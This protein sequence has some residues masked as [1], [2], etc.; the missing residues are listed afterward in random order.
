MEDADVYVMDHTDNVVIYCCMGTGDD[1]L[2]QLAYS[3][4]ADGNITLST[5]PPFV[6]QPVTSYVPEPVETMET[7]TV[8]NMAS[9]D[10]GDT[11]TRFADRDRADFLRVAML[12]NDKP[13]IL[14]V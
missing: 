14:L 10:A 11:A 4:D 9:M 5:D 2:Y 13:N 3:A 8:P 7:S 12:E 1:D 6:V